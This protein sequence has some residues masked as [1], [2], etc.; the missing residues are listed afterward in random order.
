LRDIR[1]VATSFD[2]DV[3]LASSEIDGPVQVPDRT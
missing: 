1:I 2:R 3:C